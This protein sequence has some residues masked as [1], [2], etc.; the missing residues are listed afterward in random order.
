MK[1]LKPIQLRRSRPISIRYPIWLALTLCL[2]WGGCSRSAST[3]LSEADPFLGNGVKIG[4][5]TSSSAIVWGRL[6]QDADHNIGGLPFASVSTEDREEL[7]RIG[8]PTQ[9]YAGQIPEDK[10]LEDM[11]AA[12]P[13]RGGEMRLIYWPDGETEQQTA[14]DWVPVDAAKDYTRQFRLDNL[15][16]ATA[17]RFRVEGRA[18]SA[19]Q[20]NALVENS[21]RTAPAPT[22]ADRVVFTVVTGQMWNTRDSQKGQK[23]YPSMSR[24]DP[25]FFVHTGDIVYY[26]TEDPWVTHIDLAR[27]KWNRSYSQPYLRDFH[28][29]VPSYFIKDDH[30]SWQND[31]W[32]TMSENR[33]GLF[34][35]D[36]G[37]DVFLEQV[38][39]GDRT[40]RTIRWGR[41]LQVWLMEGRDFRSPN[42]APDG[43]DKTIWGN[44]QMEWFKQTVA[45]SNATFRI[46]ISPTP[47]V[48][49]D[50]LWKE[51]TA[52][53]HVASRRSYEGTLL[54]EYL[55]AQKD[56]VVV[57]GDRHWQ[58]VSEDPSSSLREYSCGP[59]T[60][61]HATELKNEDHRMIRF[62]RAK[63]GFLSVTVDRVNGTPTAIFRHHDVDGRVVNEDTRQATP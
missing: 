52:D 13:G 47:V 49:P 26:D 22:A 1:T 7:A 51:N 15:L 45:A 5:V 55:G 34:D 27:F 54:R 23:I 58:Y 8:G 39:M 60:D 31:D 38:P 25:S 57:C 53:N 35:W 24:L 36:Q 9:G 33:M 14:L 17:Y 30:D 4:E 44:A 42:D 2:T 21:F 18:A 50:H 6:T 29:H 28:D 3:T 61:Q 11:E 12:L 19:S 63:G 32:P 43:P 20:I 48:G 37:K 46:L 40:Y 62:L 59:T 16:P 41:D 10:G 56:M